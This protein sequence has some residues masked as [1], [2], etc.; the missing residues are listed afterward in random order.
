MSRMTSWLC[1]SLLLGVF[2]AVAGYVLR[3]RARAGI[4]MP[5]YSVYSEDGEGLSEAAHIL[6]R[7]GWTPVA[8]TRPIQNTGR[9]GLLILAEPKR[10]GQFADESDALNDAETQSILRWVEEGNTL[11]LAGRRGSHLHQV[12]GVQTT[13]SSG[14]GAESLEVARLGASGAYLTDVTRLVVD[15]RDTL[16]APAGL[17]LWWVG[18]K[19]GAVLL[20]HGKGRVIVVADPGILTNRGISRDDNVFFLRNVAE[21]NAREGRVYIDEYHHGF[22]SAGGFWGYL[23][24]Y[25]LHWAILP[26]LIVVGVVAWH[27]AV[28]LGPAVA[29]PRFEQ[30]D[31]V[32]YASA[33]ARLYRRAGS[34][35]LLARTLARGFQ[36]ALTKHLHLRGNALPAE[37]LA[38]WGQSDAGASMERLK[39]LLRG[40]AELRKGEVNERRLL[41]WTRAF[42]DFQR[43]A[44]D[45]G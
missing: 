23:G 2:L 45:A 25:H 32:D 31:A 5:A 27:C 42:D 17:P 37:I 16:F 43:T 4:G 7:L 10:S 6:G 1:V 28:R 14:S 34:R 36:S 12:L 9:K 19:A 8:I 3:E 18:G 21:L 35:R 33:L 15:N 29:T 30:A 44:I 40:L 20:R 38:A 39:S 13:G 24:H 22:R 11:M 26:L 41:H